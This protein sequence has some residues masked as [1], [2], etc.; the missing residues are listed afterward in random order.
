MDEGRNKDRES[1][2]VG[3]QTAPL[4][5]AEAAEVALLAE[6]LASPSTWAEPSA[7]LEEAVVRAVAAAEP[8]VRPPPMSVTDRHREAGTRRWRVALSAA[9]AAIVVVVGAA[10]LTRGGPSP[11]F[12]AELASTGLVPGASG[13][14]E[15]TRN[16]GGFRI[17][18]EAHS[19]P[20]LPRGEYYEAWL[21]STAGTLVPIGTFSS[22]D[23]TITLWSGRSPADFPTITVTIEAADNAQTSSGRVVLSGRLSSPSSERDDR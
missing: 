22:S 12:E 6:L 13:S 17:T 18:L 7:G 4:D 5:A 2:I 19:L 16:D 20:A 9:A 21:K 8:A 3:D 11:D 23:E 10:V 1:L 14:V 15:V